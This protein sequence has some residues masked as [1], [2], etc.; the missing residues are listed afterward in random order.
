[1]AKLQAQVQEMQFTGDAWFGVYKEYY[2]W[3][4]SYQNQTPG[5]FYWGYGEPSNSGNKEECGVIHPAGT[6]W[7][8]PCAWTIPCWCYDGE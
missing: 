8:V 2:S 3:H 5:L 4:W 6:W 1:M 7:D